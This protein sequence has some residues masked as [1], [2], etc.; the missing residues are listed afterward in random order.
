MKKL[1]YTLMAGLVALPMTAQGL[2]EQYE[3]V[4]TTPRSYVCYRADGKIKVDGKLNEAS[5][6]KAAYTESFVDI[7]GAGFATPKYDTR[8][9][10]V[11]DDDYLY[12]SAILEEDNIIAKLSQRDTIIYYDNDFEVFLDPDWNGQNYFEIETNARGVI[13]DLMLDKPYRCGGNFMVQWD[14]PGLK[15]AIG[16]NGTLNK[17]KDKDQSWTVEMAIPHKALTVNFSNPLKAGNTWRINFSRVQ[18]LKA[19]GPEDNWV[20]SPTGKIDMHMPDR[21][22]Y[23][24]FA[25][26]TVGTQTVEMVYPYHTGVYQLLWAMFYK[27]QEHYAKEKCYL[28]HIERFF[29]TESDLARIPQDANIVV[30]AAKDCYRMAIC[31]PS[32]G[33]R[34]ILNDEGRF[35]IEAVTK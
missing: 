16:L 14:C 20:W 22:G 18:W 21:W 24:Y 7:S 26:K 17:E 9:Q 8:A 33:K 5:W 13:F 10:M 23:L 6:Q 11:W 31:V 2:F 19:K 28:R 29:L 1:F 4:L 35:W 32:E 34:Y 25:D 12:V 3:R 27:Q 15:T 30:D